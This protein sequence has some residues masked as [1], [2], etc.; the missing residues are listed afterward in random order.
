MRLNPVRAFRDPVTRP[1][2]LI[3]ALVA[4]M[5]FVVLWTVGIVGTCPEWFCTDPCHVVHDDN[6]LAYEASTHTNVSCIACHEPLN[7][8]PFEMTYMK[9][10]VLPDLTATIFG[11]YEVPVNPA[12]HTAVEFPDDRCTQC[13]NLA[14]R[15][16]TPTQG[17][18]ID[19]DIHT[20]N[21]VTCA[22]CHN[23]VAHP[24]DE[25]ELILGDR[26]HDDWMSMDACF[27]CHSLEQ[28]AKAPGRCEACHPKSFD[29]VPASHDAT[30][31][32]YAK[33]ETSKGHARAAKEESATL[34]EATAHFA[35]FEHVD[36]KHAEGPVLEPSSAVNS[37]YTCHERSFCSDCHKLP[38]PHPEAFAKDHGEEG[39]RMPDACANCHARNAKEAKGTAFCDACHHP[40]KE[41]G[42]SWIKTHRRSVISEGG[43]ACFKCHDPQYCETCHVS[44]PEAAADF[45]RE[46]YED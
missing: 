32:W 25:I 39:F 13:H 31:G 7:A 11:T 1:R 45:A 8:N 41:P 24:E 36:E 21:E 22:T 17:I 42:A 38:M 16:V 4:L 29:L 2:A 26:K 23:R 3:W 20:D 40:T 14:N 18:L 10:Y 9:I 5:G 33:Y 35:E 15:P 28:G 19:H 34:A 37:C 30:S 46:N 27:R 44:G 43:N 6:T 12:S